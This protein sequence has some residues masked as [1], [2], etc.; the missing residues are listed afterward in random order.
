MYFVILAVILPLLVAYSCKT[1]CNL[2]SWPSGERRNQCQVEPSSPLRCTAIPE[3]THS[4]RQS[5]WLYSLAVRIHQVGSLEDKNSL[6]R[7]SQYRGA[8][9]PVGQPRS[10]PPLPN[11]F[12]TGPDKRIGNGGTGESGPTTVGLDWRKVSVRNGAGGRSCVA[13]SAAVSGIVMKL[14]DGSRENKMRID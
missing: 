14:W 11:P 1:D 6:Y 3:P 9:L 5:E 10:F 8:N 13:C 12:W 2:S 7:H 4:T